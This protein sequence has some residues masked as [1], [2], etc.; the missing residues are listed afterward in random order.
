MMRGNAAICGCIGNCAGGWTY[1]DR[2]KGNNTKL[3][4]ALLENRIMKTPFINIGKV[5]AL[6]ATFST[7]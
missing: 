7:L 2:L 6:L 5:Y 3:T 1:V 4:R